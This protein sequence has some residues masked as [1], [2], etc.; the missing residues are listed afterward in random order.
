MESSEKNEKNEI[1][2]FNFKKALFKAKKCTYRCCVVSW[3]YGS[4][5]LRHFSI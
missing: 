1:I 3:L 2:N 5:P 4:Y